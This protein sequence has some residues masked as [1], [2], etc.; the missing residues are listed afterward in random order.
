MQVKLVPGALRCE[1]GQER[2]TRARADGLECS[3]DGTIIH[4]CGWA[5]RVET[6]H[7]GSPNE[8]SADLTP[9]RSKTIHVKVTK[10]FG[11]IL[12][13]A[14]GGNKS[15]QRCFDFRFGLRR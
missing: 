13:F 10:N 8:V 15:N 5:N 7:E 11:A 2:K 9:M 1:R 6:H 3:L 14:R 4:I 12:F